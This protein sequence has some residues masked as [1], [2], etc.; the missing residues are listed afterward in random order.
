MNRQTNISNGG[1]PFG[2]FTAPT[3][4]FPVNRDF[5]NYNQSF[6]PNENI[7]Q[8][9]DFRNKNML[10]HNNVADNIL[11]EYVAEYHVHVDSGDRS[12]SVYPNPCKFTVTF[13]GSGPQE[14]K[15]RFIEKSKDGTQNIFYDKVLIPGTPG[16]VIQRKFKNVKYIKLDYLIMPKTFALTVDASGIYHFSTDTNDLI[17][18]YK[19]II[20]KIKELSSQRIVSTNNIITDDCIIM[21]PDRLLG[22]SENI[23]YVSSNPSRIFNNGKL[24]NLD[25]LTISILDPQGNELIVLDKTNN[26]EIDMKGI[27]DG[28]SK[29][30]NISISSL[31]SLYS[32]LQIN[33]SLL[34]GQVENEIHNDTK[35]EN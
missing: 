3:S 27:E 13:G 7:I 25:K 11:S 1:N 6:T 35:F 23:I 29:Y 22:G 18:K 17:T 31:K 14:V 12:I 8:K 24:G 5:Y 32:Q 9:P 10:L 33:L 34:V 15:Q 28:N 30:T 4:N 20:I 19:Y 21:Y 16:P 2:N 26:K